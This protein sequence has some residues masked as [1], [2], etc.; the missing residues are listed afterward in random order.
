MIPHLQLLQ[1]GISTK[2]EC[3][4][5]NTDDDCRLDINPDCSCYIISDYRLVDPCNLL[6]PWAL[7]PNQFTGYECNGSQP[8]APK[9]TSGVVI[10]A[11]KKEFNKITSICIS[12]SQCEAKTGKAKNHLCRRPVRLIPPTLT[13]ARVPLH[14]VLILSMNKKA[15]WM[16]AVRPDARTV[17]ARIWD[18]FWQDQIVWYWGYF[19][20]K[21]NSMGVA[22]F[23]FWRN[24]RPP[25]MTHNWFGNVAN[26]LTCG[27]CI[28]QAK[29]Q[30]PHWRPVVD[31]V[32]SR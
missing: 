17:R 15:R 31:T 11:Q 7:G 25:L 22:H 12:S 1:S 20:P 23:F 4:V 10:T 2:K 30:Y 24:H 8:S 29:M 28:C 26:W 6:L 21:V 18:A 3:S 16:I 5:C 19:V 27:L 32:Q 9:K 14:Q 13:C